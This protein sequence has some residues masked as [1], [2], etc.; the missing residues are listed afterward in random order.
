M[1]GIRNPQ[2]VL[3]FSVS[4]NL[5]QSTQLKKK[6][7]EVMRKPGASGTAKV[8]RETSQMPVARGAGTV[9]WL[10]PAHRVPLSSVSKLCA[11]EG[12]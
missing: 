2:L 11:G 9:A 4:L 1:K 7:K 5:F 8:F 3:S 12:C 10:L 6:K